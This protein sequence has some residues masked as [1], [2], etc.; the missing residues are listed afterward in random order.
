MPVSCME[1]IYYEDAGIL[2]GAILYVAGKAM[3]EP[4]EAFSSKRR[5]SSHHVL[6]VYLCK[7]CR[8]R[9][10]I[11]KLY[12][13]RYVPPAA[14]LEDSGPNDQRHTRR[15]IEVCVLSPFPMLAKLPAMI[16]VKNYDCIIVQ[17]V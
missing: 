9:H 4:H 8:C 17:V 16:R 11:Y 10:Q 14:M 13:S 5:L 15:K 3:D 1:L 12:E 6:H 7:I 2:A